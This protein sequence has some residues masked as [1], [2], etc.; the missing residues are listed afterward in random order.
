MPQPDL[1]ASDRDALAGELALGVLDGEDR[2]SALRL[3]LADRDF[4]GQVDAWRTR[5]AGLFDGFEEATPP[6][7]AWDAIAARIGAARPA[8]VAANDR[9]WKVGTFGSMAL[10]AALALALVLPNQT[11]PGPASADRYAVAQL[12]GDIEG[13][14][15]AARYDAG[16][17]TLR[18]RA[19]GMPDTPTEPELWVVPADGVPRSL[20]QISRDG[21]TV[22]L[23]AQGHR[24]LINPAAAFG[25]SMEPASE[26]P[27][28]APSA[29]IV[30][31]G[32]IDLI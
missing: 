3:M 12:T 26:T 21:E 19:S 1:T 5:T 31:S 14:R 23:V 25:L 4:A 6:P 15:I 7:G 16:S 9:W 28:T 29:P 8:P 20:G 27:H 24:S 22:I 11:A 13:L 2:A 17:A 10:A 32:A 18:V 30:A